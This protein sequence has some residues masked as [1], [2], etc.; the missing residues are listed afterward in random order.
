MTLIILIVSEWELAS[1]TNNTKNR[2]KALVPFEPFILVTNFHYQVKCYFYFKY[3]N[4]RIFGILIL[5][6]Y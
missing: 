6:F 4:I 2:P 3:N 1:I 5:C